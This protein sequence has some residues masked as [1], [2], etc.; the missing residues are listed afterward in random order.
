[1][2]DQLRA[3]QQQF[4]YLPADQLQQLASKINVPVSQIHTVASF[5]PHFH[6]T[7][8]PR[9]EVKVC[10]DMSCHLRG[11]RDLKASLEQAF[12]GGSPE[13]IS[14]RDVSCLGRC[15]KAPAFSLNDS[16]YSNLETPN[17]LVLVRD[18]L[19]G[20]QLPPQ[21]RDHPGTPVLSDPYSGSPNYSVVRRFVETRDWSGILATL[22]ASGLRGMGGAGFPTASKWEIVRNAPGQAKYI[23]CNADESEPG[24]IKDRFILETVP[25]LVIEGMITAGLVTGA[26]QGILYIRHEYEQPKEVLREEIDRCYRAGLLGKNILGSELAFDLEIFVSPGGYICGEES[27]LLE[28][29]EGKRAEPRNKPPFPGTN[30][31]WNQPTAINNVETF[32]FATVILARGAD[33]FKAQGKNGS[34]G[35]KFVGVSGDVNR[36]GVFEVPMGTKYAE[37]IHELAGGVLENRK[38]LAFAPSGPS[39]G[40][41]PASMA[42]LPLDWNAVAAAGSMVGSGAIVV[43]AEGRCMLDMALNAVRFYRNESCGKCVPCRVGSQKMV[44]M[45]AGWTEGRSSS[46]DRPLLDE[47]ST[48]MKLTSICGLG[49]VVPVPIASVLKHFP[50]VVEEHLSARRCS[51]GVCFRNRGTA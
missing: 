20:R 28:A 15:D 8:P 48:A 42:D 50:E 39:S 33:W 14:I 25:H 22:K 12:R 36:P 34:A 32:T 43:C 26:R 30:G 35:M 10:A 21:A 29:I 18:A 24:T 5:Y 4:G 46:T 11:G 16:I 7:P 1:M 40:Y 31:L 3:I 19:A 23:V 27:A 13:G 17:A 38:L 37:L 41:L 45:L 49:Q 9:A 2:F 44:E 6:L 47:L 51:A